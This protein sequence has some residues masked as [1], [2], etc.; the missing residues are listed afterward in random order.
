MHIAARGVEFPRNRV[1]VT[2]SRRSIVNVHSRQPANMDGN[3]R[4]T[5]PL[6]VKPRSTSTPHVASVTRQ[7]PQQH[8]SKVVLETFSVPSPPS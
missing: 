5:P 2:T 1:I 8:H 3:D 6:A 7:Q 4:T